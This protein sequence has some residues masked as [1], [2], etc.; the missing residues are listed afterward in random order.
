LEGTISAGQKRDLAVLVEEIIKNEEISG[1][2]DPAFTVRNEPEII[3]PD[4]RLYRPDRVLVRDGRITII[5]YK[6]GS[7][8]KEHQDQVLKYADL[9][10][11]MDFTVDGAYLL[12]L[13]RRP[14]L[15]KVV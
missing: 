12:Y 3:T 1:F 9:V 15:H 8:K 13:N 5:D 7:R 4:G 10:R 6:T 2:F 11:E 14:E